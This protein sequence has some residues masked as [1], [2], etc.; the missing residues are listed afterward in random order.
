[1]TPEE[2]DALLTTVDVDWQ[3]L[4]EIMSG[5]QLS[6]IAE[7][8]QAIVR[9]VAALA[10]LELAIRQMGSAEAEQGSRDMA[11]TGAD[12][13]KAFDATTEA[14]RAALIATSPDPKGLKEIF[15]E[16][17]DDDITCL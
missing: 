3:R 6:R 5:Y 10:A 15:A 11:T 12:L 8:S 13:R 7:L 14:E 4:R 2:L 1:M 16:L 17:D 9:H